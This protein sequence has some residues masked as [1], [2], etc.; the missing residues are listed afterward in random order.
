M[1]LLP[2]QLRIAI[3]ERTPVAFVRQGNTIGT[4]RCSWCSAAPASGRDGRQALLLPCGLRA[5]LP[6]IRYRSALRACSCTSNS[7]T[8][9]TPGETKVSNQLSEVDISDPED[10]W[11]LLPAQGS[12]IQV[13]FG[14]S[15]F[16][17]RY[18]SYQQH[19]PEWRQQYPHLASVDMRYERPGGARYDSAISRTGCPVQPASG[20]ELRDE[21]CAG[22]T[23]AKPAARSPKAGKAKG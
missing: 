18:R 8:T 11:A 2:D 4:G 21:T 13:H 23:A 20:G 16:L 19:L 6:R 10:V 7:S 3:V 15:D 17:A 12:D 22:I 14:D 5:S 1:R 9:L